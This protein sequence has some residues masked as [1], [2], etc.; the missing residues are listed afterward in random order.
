M[1]RRR[2]V[3]LVVA[4]IAVALLAAGPLWGHLRESRADGLAV[5]YGAAT[6]E[7]AATLADRCTGVMREDYATTSDP[8]VAGIGPKT[9]AFLVPKVCT[10]GVARGLVADDGT[11]SEQ[12]GFE[13]TTAVTKRMGQERIQTLIF[14]EL[15]VGQYHLAEPGKVTRWHR[16]VAMAYSGWDAQPDGVADPSATKLWRR[17]SRQ[18][19]K[20]GV[21]RG[22]VPKSGA[23]AVGTAAADELNHLILS[24]LG[25][26]AQD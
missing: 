2:G 3:F 20:L 12:S 4:V 25:N 5:K 26:L 17:A 23:P 7:G 22:I 14:D 8:R 13:L 21:Q 16:C 6:S 10:L 9:Y 24:T 18:A 19:C 1:R 15:A 11:M